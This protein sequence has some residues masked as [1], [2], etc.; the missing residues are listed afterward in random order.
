MNPEKEIAKI[1]EEIA[2]LEGK[3]V[4]AFSGGADSTLV[5]YICKMVDE[6]SVAV[7]IKGEA[8]PEREIE[9]AKMLAE[10]LGL[11]HRILELSQLK[12]P[13]FMQNP[14]ERCYYCKK[15][16]IYRTMVEFPKA[17]I[18]DGSN[19]SDFSDYRPGIKAIKDLG[20]ISPLK[21]YT[22][23]Q[24]R[25][26]AK[27]LKL[28]NWDKPPA[29]CTATRV[30]FNHQITKDLL[31][32]IERAEDRLLELGFR[33]VRVRVYQT[34]NGDDVRLQVAEDEV[35]RAFEIRKEIAS[36]LRE[37]GFSRVALDVEGYRVL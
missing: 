9:Y 31:S 25:E 4:V 6:D 29:S 8:I 17:K 21:N 19:A 11:N 3:K 28:P 5:A 23:E 33:V 37:F 26:L 15:A 1:R 18:L 27:Q 14:P 36:I 35:S 16:M 12:I 34:F 32:R 13:G 24:V 2:S 30:Q 20:V 10:K 22:K 7:T